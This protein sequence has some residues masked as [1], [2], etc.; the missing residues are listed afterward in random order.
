M[1]KLQRMSVFVR[2]LQDEGNTYIIT[3]GSP[4]MIFS[5]SRKETSISLLLLF[6]LSAFI[7]DFLKFITFEKQVKKNFKWATNSSKNGNEL[8]ILFLLHPFFFLINFAFF[9]FRF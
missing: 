8:F 1:P 9:I 6:L 2:D 5:L 7:F 3:K 4:E